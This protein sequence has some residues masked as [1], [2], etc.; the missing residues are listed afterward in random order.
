MVGGGRGEGTEVCLTVQMALTDPGCILS[1]D[2]LVAAASHQLR[3]SHVH[4]VANSG[5]DRKEK[6]GGQGGR[7]WRH[8]VVW[9]TAGLASA[10]ARVYALAIQP[11]ASRFPSVKWAQY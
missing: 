9:G 11:S 4:V 8:R 5:G 10:S 6:A 3:G 7:S 2:K 1:V